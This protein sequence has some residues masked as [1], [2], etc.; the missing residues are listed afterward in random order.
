MYDMNV[1]FCDFCFSFH[2]LSRIVVFLFKKKLIFIK[3][4]NNIINKKKFYDR[5]IT[6]SQIFNDGFDFRVKR[7]L[8]QTL[9]DSFLEMHEQPASTF[10][11]KSQEWN[12]I[13]GLVMNEH[14]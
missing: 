14:I 7:I 2:R 5:W 4:N 12:R 1:V 13:K 11:L 3:I 8:Y 6:Y 10:F 9:G